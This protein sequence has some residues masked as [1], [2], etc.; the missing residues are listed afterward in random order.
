M[1]T[2]IRKLFWFAMFLVATFCF[3]VLFEHGTTDFVKNAQ[4][5]FENV[6]KL[7]QSHLEK[8][9]DDSDAGAR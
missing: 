3:V 1:L 2:L 7:Y 9:K 4:V 6:K 8:K 5:E